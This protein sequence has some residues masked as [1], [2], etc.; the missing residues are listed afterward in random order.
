MTVQVPVP[1]LDT[2]RLVL[3]GHLVTDLDDSFAMWSS[4]EVLRI[5]GKPLTREEVWA[6]LLR[7]IGHWAVL[8][9]G[10]WHVRE[11]ATDRFVGEVGI[12]DFRRDLAFPFDAAPEAAWVIAPWAHGLGYATE[13][14]TAVLAWAGAAHPRTVCI[15]DPDNFASLRVAAKLGYHEIGRADFKGHPII[16]FERSVT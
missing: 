2:P 10:L 4:P 16:V 1:V 8:D 14:M 9:Y 7:Y 3:R 15:I 5:T 11:R 12:A 6:R 13:A